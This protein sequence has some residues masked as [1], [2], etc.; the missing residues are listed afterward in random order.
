MKTKTRRHKAPGKPFRKGLSLLKLTR[1]FPDDESA[2][3]WLIQARWP[4]GVRCPKC[5]SDNIQERATRKPQPFRCRACRKDFS[6]K[7]DTLM[8]NS[9]LGCRIWVLAIYL[10][11]TSL[12]GV[13]S[14]KLHRDLGITQKSAWYL[15]HRIRA[16]FADANGEFSGPVE[17]DEAYLGG[18]RRNMPL[19][20]RKPLRGRGAVGKV[21]V[22]GA[23]DRSTNQIRA[24]VVENTTGATLQDFVRD[25]IRPG[26]KLY[27]DGSAA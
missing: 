15:E 17:I 5:E 22:A 24:T 1:L 13:S 12:K 10:M 7:T 20:K 21:A 18:K 27:T 25:R 3:K 26:A 8:H 23:K 2:E 16:T 11:T 9:P 4:K 19:S 14:M 6:V